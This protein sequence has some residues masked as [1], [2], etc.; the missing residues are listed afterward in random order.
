MA[1]LS[2]NVSIGKDQIVLVILSK[3]AKKDIERLP[4][5][6]VKAWLKQE[7]LLPDVNNR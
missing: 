1:L 2:S 7:T 6:R 4:P 3:F 5:A